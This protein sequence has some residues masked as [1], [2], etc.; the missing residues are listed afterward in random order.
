[1]IDHLCTLYKHTPDSYILKVF[2]NLLGAYNTKVSKSTD[3]QKDQQ[4]QFLI[5]QALS[6]VSTTTL[7]LFARDKNTRPDLT[8]QYFDLVSQVIFINCKIYAI[9]ILSQRLI[10]ESI[11]RNL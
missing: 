1:M 7:A 3:T 6:Y 10:K 2:Y 11:R 4:K 9:C 8:K 5:S